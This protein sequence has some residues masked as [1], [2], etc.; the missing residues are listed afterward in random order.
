MNWSPR[1]TE[2]SASGSLNLNGGHDR[3]KP[4]LVA[5]HGESFDPH[6]RTRQQLHDLRPEA[7]GHRGLRGP[8]LKVAG[9]DHRLIERQE[10]LA[11]SDEPSR[12][13]IRVFHAE[14]LRGRGGHSDVLSRSHCQ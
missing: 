1:R 14:R 8:G 12:T 11:I 5:R 2:R 13:V 10:S 6:S 3:V 4:L 9:H 7:L